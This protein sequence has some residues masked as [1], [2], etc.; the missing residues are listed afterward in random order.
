MRNKIL[1]SFIAISLWLSPHLYANTGKI[2]AIE[3]ENG[4]HQKTIEQNEKALI[5]NKEDIDGALDA[6]DAAKLSLVKYEEA[7]AV[8]EGKYSKDS[9]PQNLKL[10][11]INKSRK[12]RAIEKVAS[13][14][15]RVS[16]LKTESNQLMLSTKSM[17]KL[18]AK[19]KS[20]I[21]RLENDLKKARLQAAAKAKQHKKTEMAKL[22]KPDVVPVVTAPRVKTSAA[23]TK[24]PVKVAKVSKAAGAPVAASATNKT[25]R[26]DPNDPVA[27]A[28]AEIKEYLSGDVSQVAKTRRRNGA[29]KRGDKIN[30]SHLGGEIYS[31]DVVLIGGKNTISFGKSVFKINVKQEDDKKLFTLFFD[32]RTKS[33]RIL[34]ME[35]ALVEKI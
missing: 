20:D 8:A 7:F 25:S 30:F 18:I 29:T 1:L 11:E 31:G 2:K 10:L 13:R 22:P 28:I 26:F 4:R 35:K 12:A 21:T 32:N 34:F 3:Q 17:D 9:S 14:E 33:R 15:Q 19:N 6:L 24:P 16:K 27:V 5:A 23:L